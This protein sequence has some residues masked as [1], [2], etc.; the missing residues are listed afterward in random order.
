VTSFLE[1]RKIK[2]YKTPLA[3]ISLGEAG[4]TYGS[5]IDNAHGHRQDTR[6]CDD[7]PEGHTQGLVAEG[8]VVEISDHGNAED[9]HQEG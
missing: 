9:Y 6:G 4:S 1:S 3:I 5:E 2:L 7:P 8:F